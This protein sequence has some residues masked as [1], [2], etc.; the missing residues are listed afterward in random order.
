MRTWTRTTG[1][2][3]SIYV[4]NDGWQI[5]GIKRSDRGDRDWEVTGPQGER[6]WHAGRSGNRPFAT[7]SAAKARVDQTARQES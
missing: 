5:T 2:R 3:A 1:T 4:S 7:L 6:L